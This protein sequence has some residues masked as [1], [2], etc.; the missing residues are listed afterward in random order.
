MKHKTEPKYSTGAPIQKGDAVMLGGTHAVVDQ[1]IL[2]GCD[3]WASYWRD[4]TGE[5]V[6]LVGP[7]FGSLF[8]DFDDEDLFFVS[9]ARL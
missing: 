3:G 7:D 1:L 4:A 6:M 2:E 8:T 5:G 9:R